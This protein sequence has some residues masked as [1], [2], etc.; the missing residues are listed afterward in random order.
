MKL[1]FLLIRI[2]G[3]GFGIGLSGALIPG[4]LLAF[5]VK[6][7]LAGGAR[8]GAVIM[9]GHIIVEALLMLLIYFGF[10]GFLTNPAVASVI[11]VLGSVLLFYLS[12]SLVKQ[13]DVLSGEPGTKHYNPVAGGIL[14]T[15][16][17]PSFPLWWATVG[18]NMLGEGMRL[19]GRAG[20]FAVVAGHWLADVG[21]YSIVSFAVAKGR[22]TMLKEKVYPVLKT[23]MAVFM[24]A[25]GLY[26]LF[27][28][29]SAALS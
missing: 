25:L 20:V 26:F 16:L 5:T 22:D 11:A 28:G 7:S 6:E 10:M 27:R 19:G 15:A 14:L 3:L 18:Y 12:Y 9:T 21:W 4:P 13:K 24:A 8:T 1:F 29:F 23:V 17:N 2:L